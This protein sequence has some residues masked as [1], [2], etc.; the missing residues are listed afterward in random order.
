MLS[1]IGA[2]LY[3]K[4]AFHHFVGISKLLYVHVEGYI[5]TVAVLSSMLLT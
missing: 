2:G 1:L 3:I 5:V 4:N